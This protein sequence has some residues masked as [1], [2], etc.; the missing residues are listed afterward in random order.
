VKDLT[1][2]IDRVVGVKQAT[3]A[4]LDRQLPI[5]QKKHTTEISLP[6]MEEGDVL[7]LD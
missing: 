1:V 2:S 6:Q 5:V 7:I 4:M 3:S